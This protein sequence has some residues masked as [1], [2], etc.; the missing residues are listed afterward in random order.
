MLCE[1]VFMFMQMIIIV[2]TIITIIDDSVMCLILILYKD[3]EII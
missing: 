3:R 1:N 2:I